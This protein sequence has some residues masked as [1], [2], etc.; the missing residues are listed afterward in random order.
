MYSDCR[1]MPPADTA[2]FQ[3]RIFQLIQE[4]CM[5]YKYSVAK[6]LQNNRKFAV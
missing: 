2:T 6:C 3:D 5:H 1:M 4:K